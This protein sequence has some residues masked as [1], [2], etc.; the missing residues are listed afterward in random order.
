MTEQLVRPYQ[1]C[2][3]CIMDTVADKA[4][5][6]DSNGLCHH[7]RRYDQLLWCRVVEPTSRPHALDAIVAQI[8]R[9][10][11]GRE[12]DCIIGVSGGV[13]STYVAYLVVARVTPARR[14]PR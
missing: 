14:T 1:I 3:R 5:W 7:C 13:D 12:Y 10:G 8:K 4:I 11:R 9:A 6:F 2:V